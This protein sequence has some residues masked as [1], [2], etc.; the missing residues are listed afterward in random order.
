MNLDINDPNFKINLEQ[1][2]VADVALTRGQ[3]AEIM[4][5]LGLWSTGEADSFFKEADPNNPFIRGSL[6]AVAEAAAG[7][8]KQTSMA[9]ESELERRESVEFATRPESLGGTERVT[10]EGKRKAEEKLQQPISPAPP[11]GPQ[12]ITDINEKR[13]VIQRVRRGNLGGRPLP[14]DAIIRDITKDAAANRYHITVVIAGRTQ[15]FTIKIDP[16]AE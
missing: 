7:A 3:F 4:A 6:K 12:P 15:E 1:A 14:K 10:R 5:D 9:G 11:S 8:G 16:D 2:R 13:R